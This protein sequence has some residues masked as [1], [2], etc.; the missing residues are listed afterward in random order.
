[1]TV[2]GMRY[3]MNCKLDSQQEQVMGS[4]CSKPLEMVKAAQEKRRT[5]RAEHCK[6]ELSKGQRCHFYA[7]PAEPGPVALERA[8]KSVDST[9]GSSRVRASHGSCGTRPQSGQHPRCQLADQHTRAQGRGLCTNALEASQLH[10]FSP[11]NIHAPV[12]SVVHRL[13]SQLHSQPAV[14][15]AP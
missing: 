2:F 10:M 6:E 15:G 11:H 4:P 8:C 12:P 14:L 7:R 5:V 1:M 3:E 13:G 9:A